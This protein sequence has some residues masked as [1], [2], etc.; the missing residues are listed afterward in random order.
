M[1]TG[2]PKV[3][4]IRIRKFSEYIMITQR[5]PHRGAEYFWQQPY[6]SCPIQKRAAHVKILCCHNAKLSTWMEDHDDLLHWSINSTEHW[7]A[8]FL[9]IARSRVMG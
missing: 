6:S 8:E 7:A 1:D 2:F 9:R 3:P 5:G 4:K